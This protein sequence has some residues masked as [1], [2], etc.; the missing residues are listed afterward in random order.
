[1]QDL[2]EDLIQGREVESQRIAGCL[3]GF[4]AGKVSP[5]Q[6]AALLVLMRTRGE[7]AEQ[8]AAFAEAVLAQ[9]TPIEI[10]EQAIDQAGTGGDHSGSFNISTTAALL[11]ASAG[12]PVAKQGNRSI[13]SR[14][15]S[16]DVLEAL[17]ININLGPGKA[18]DCL[19]KHGF[20][21]LFAPVYHPAY[22]HVAPVRNALNIRTIFNVCGPL[23]HPGRLKRQVIG[24]YDRAL[25]NMVADAA[26]RL[27]KET[28][29]VLSS[30]DGLDE[31]S[32]AA[33]TQARV[34]EG[35]K[36]TDL[37]IDPRDFG[38]PL[39]DLDALS[40]GTA[41]ENAEITRGILSGEPGPR[42]DCA[43]LNSAAALFVS[44]QARNLA[45]GVD[46]AR[47]IQQSGKG[48]ALIEALVEFN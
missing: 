37:E 34:V 17:G 5:E 32:L 44:G 21:F 41:E 26:V 15:G 29:M 6:L 43:I 11:T 22:K 9:A 28:I 19:D 16:A 7:T 8:L 42:S 45:E 39:C 4:F 10:P 48:L 40:G 30:T 33:P 36:I 20:C 3:T 2:L 12:L 25:I 35:K 47:A 14:S 18:R 23:I 24:V 31:I 13:T 46:M 27:G 1:M 38:L